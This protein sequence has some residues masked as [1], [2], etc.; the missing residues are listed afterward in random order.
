MLPVCGWDDLEAE[1]GALSSPN[2]GSMPAS[3][4]ESTD[5]F[6]SLHVGSLVVYYPSFKNSLEF[7][8]IW[9]HQIAKTSNLNNYITMTKYIYSIF[10]LFVLKSLVSFGCNIGSCGS[11]SNTP[12]PIVNSASLASSSQHSQDGKPGF[13]R[14]W[15]ESHWCRL[16]W[17]AKTCYIMYPHV[18]KE[19]QLQHKPIT[20][21]QA[22]ATERGASSASSVLY[23]RSLKKMAW[24]FSWK[25]GAI[26]T[27]RCILL[28]LA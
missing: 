10:V 24:W 16:S 3:L 17:L 25:S 7:F 20:I 19:R 8:N 22:V 28:L 15:I 13:A 27:A 18:Y 2:L 23:L 12:T 26:C 1:S 6:D 21:V 14:T 11:T 5:D 9:T 4:W